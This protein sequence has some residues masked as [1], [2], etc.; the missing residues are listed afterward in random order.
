MHLAR[1]KK[2]EAKKQVFLRRRKALQRG[3]KKGS[4]GP[5]KKLRVKVHQPSYPRTER[6]KGETGSQPLT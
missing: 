2:G 6:E 5:D 1:R 4:S 3:E